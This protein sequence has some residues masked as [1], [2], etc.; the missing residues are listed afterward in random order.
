MNNDKNKGFTRFPFFIIFIG[1]AAPMILYAN[2]LGEVTLVSLWLPVVLSIV[3]GLAIFGLSYL[4][5]KDIL[6]SG[7][8]TGIIEILIFS[9]GHIYNLV[10]PLTL[11]GVLVGRHRYL[12]PL[13]LLIFGFLLWRVIKSKGNFTKI[14]LLLNIVTMML[15]AFQFVRISIF[16]IKTYQQQREGIDQANQTAEMGFIGERPD[17]YIIL[18]DGY[19]RSD[20]LADSIGYDNSAFIQ[21]LQDL[22]FYVPSCSMSNYSYTL[23]SITSELNMTYLDELFDPL[24]DIET[25]SLLKHSEVRRILDSLGYETVFFQNFYPWVDINDGDYYL[26]PEDV[27]KYNPFEALFLETTVLTV[28][29]DLFERQ[30]AE[31]K[32]SPDHEDTTRYANLIQSI[33]DYLQ[34]PHNY[35]EPAFVYAHVLNPHSP[36]VFNADGSINYEWEEDPQEAQLRTYQYLDIQTIEA[37][38]VILESSDPDPIIIIQ[39]DHGMGE[40]DYKNLSLNAFYLPNGGEQMLYSTIT[41]VNFFRIIFD[42]YFGMDFDLLED[43]SYYSEKD[44]RYILEEVQEP[45]DYCK[46]QTE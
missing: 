8:V 4:F 10:K 15:F 26:K 5:F 28:P 1:A 32:W 22:G 44:S 23:L 29:Y 35:K 31:L 45:Y 18:L 16:E 3:V 39:S 41:P 34:Q 25:T 2:N 43:K 42:Y 9:Y 19:M 17:I 13:L 40:R 6:K 33:F 7:L 36:Y 21:E 11:F 46:S 30:I 14:T 27:S 24:E 20:W 12:F 38:K 37:V